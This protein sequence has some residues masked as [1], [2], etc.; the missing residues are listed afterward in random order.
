MDSNQVLRRIGEIGIVP[1]IRTDSVEHTLRAVDALYAGG[2]PIVEITMTVPEANR[3]IASVVRQFGDSILVGAGTV[4]RSADARKSIDSG[5]QFLV[6]PGMSEA[7]L[8]TGKEQG[9]LVIPGA[10]TPTEVMNAL[11]KGAAVIKIF[12]CSSGGGAA[13]VRAL[14]GPF[15][16]VSLIPTGGINASN[17]AEYIA[18]GAFALGAGSDLVD[19]TSLKNGNSDRITSAARQFVAA[20]SRARKMRPEPKITDSPTPAV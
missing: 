2:I 1:V 3:A 8:Q 5:A 7:V 4:I 14:R 19:P 16:R 17:A 11:E 13:H 6:S 9:I 12:P 10:F 20:V 15:P 18:A